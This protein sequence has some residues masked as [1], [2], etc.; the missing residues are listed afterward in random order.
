VN[1]VIAE[2]MRLIGIDGLAYATEAQL[3][4]LRAIG[5]DLVN[6]V[7]AGVR[8]QAEDAAR[9]QGWCPGCI[10]RG[11]GENCLLCRRA[12]PVTLIRTGASPSEY[13]HS[14][15]DCRLGRVHVHEAGEAR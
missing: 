8:V 4:Q 13:R 12:I 3:R 2:L 14:C 11:T 10:G 9:P 6:L 7:D 15:P 1:A 5:E